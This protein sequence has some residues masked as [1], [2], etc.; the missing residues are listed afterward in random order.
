MNLPFWSK[1]IGLFHAFMLVCCVCL[2]NDD[3]FKQART[4][5]REGKHGEAIAAFKNYL[6]QPVPGNE[7]SD[8][9]MVRYTDALVQLSSLRSGVLRVSARELL[10]EIQAADKEMKLHYSK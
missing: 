2:A 6:T 3:L 9:Q 10:A 7:L 5:Q 4:L 8:E 1:K